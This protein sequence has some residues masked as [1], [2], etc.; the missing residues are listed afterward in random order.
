MARAVT[1][2]VALITGV[3]GGIGQATAEAFKRAG[4]S[5]TGVDIAEPPEDL[6]VDRYERVD[7]SNPDQIAQFFAGID[8]RYGRLDALVNN[9]AIQIDKSIIATTD[10]E[11]DLV[12]NTNLR[13]A[14]QCTRAAHPLLAAAKG[15]IVNV[16][17]VHAITTSI[18]V[19]AYAISKAALGGL[20]R[21]TAVEFAADGVRC[22]A[23]LPGAIDT[24]MLRAGLNRRPHPDGV[25][26]NMANL[27]DRT[28]LGFVALP[29]QIAPTIVHLADNAQSPYTTGQLIVVDGGASISLSTE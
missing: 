10:A 29:N 5:V 2:K 9:A 22:N 21:T 15:A 6:P 19:A 12:I 3:L 14:F 18:N 4:W 16:S 8:K 1:E 26:G 24:A 27:A 25:E 23:V 13:S 7:I 17:S 20:T 28:P 11:W